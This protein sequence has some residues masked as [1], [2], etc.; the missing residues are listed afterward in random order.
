MKR[1][2]ESMFVFDGTLPEDAIE[3][4]QKQVE[5]FL[6]ANADFEKADVWGKKQLAYPIKKKKSGYYVLFLYQGEG[7]VPAAL[8][9]H[10]KLN[11]SVLRHLT[12]LR[13]L[14]NEAAREA[15]VARREQKVEAQES[16][17]AET[18]SSTAEK[19]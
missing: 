16:S 17:E 2:Y 1:P 15:L 3:K 6:S 19:E 10:I 13:D 7:T 5:E 4:E 9:K 11:E 12:V 14:K 18:E 8:E